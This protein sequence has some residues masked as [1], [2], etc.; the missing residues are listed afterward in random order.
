M[1]VVSISLVVAMR[2]SENEG[3]AVLS[4]RTMAG[5]ASAVSKISESVDLR[6]PKRLTL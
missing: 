5:F 2:P 4:I 6:V 3:S 1:S